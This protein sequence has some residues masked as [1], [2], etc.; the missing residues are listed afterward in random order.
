MQTKSVAVLA[1]S[2]ATAC[3]LTGPSSPVGSYR[4]VKFGVDAIPVQLFELPDEHGQ[5]TGCWYA[6][7]EGTLHLESAPAHFSYELIYRNSCTNAVLFD[8]VVEGHYEGDGEEL[9]FFVNATDGG[10]SF[11]VEWHDDRLIVREDASHVYTFK[12][13]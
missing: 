8:N 11:P 12:K 1:S 10:I 5:P 9:T 6:L 4:L 7:T 13:T 2:L 3:F